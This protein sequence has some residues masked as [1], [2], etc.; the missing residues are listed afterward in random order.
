MFQEIHFEVRERR[1]QSYLYE[2][3]LIKRGRAAVKGVTYPII[4][5]HEKNQPVLRIIGHDVSNLYCR[6]SIQDGKGAYHPGL[7]QT[8]LHRVG[9]IH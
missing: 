9:R 2:H 8:V 5:T 3:A 7:Y 6:L 1:S 4:R